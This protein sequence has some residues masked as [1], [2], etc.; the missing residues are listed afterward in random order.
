MDVYYT[1]LRLDFAEAL[2]CR[3]KERYNNVSGVVLIVSDNL[4][5]LPISHS[6]YELTVLLL[7]HL[8]CHSVIQ[9]VHSS[10]FWNGLQFV[11]T[12][13]WYEEDS[14]YHND[15]SV[16][17]QTMQF[18]WSSSKKRGRE[19]EIDGDCDMQL[20]CYGHAIILSKPQYFYVECKWRDEDHFVFHFIRFNLNSGDIN[21]KSNR[22]TKSSQSKDGKS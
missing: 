14:E 7:L 11:S 8:Q 16:Y 1:A 12:C 9:S 2:I 10:C 15:P 13:W 6:Y 3:E 18:A 22:K 21:R 17:R 5:E 20:E 4:L 19:K